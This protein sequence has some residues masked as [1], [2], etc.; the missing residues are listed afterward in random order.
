MNPID[1]SD[2][3]APPAPLGAAVAQALQSLGEG[4]RIDRRGFVRGLGL[5]GAMAGLALS[6]CAPQ[7]QP[8]GQQ[9]Q[10]VIPTPAP[11]LRAAFSHNGLKSLWNARGRDTAQFLGKLL[12]IDVI[13]YDGNLDVDKQR[14]DLEEIAEQKWDF[15]A[16]HPLAVNAYFDPVRKL[17][18]GGIPVIDMDTRLADDLEGLGVVTFLEPDNVWMGE[19]VT[20]AI[21]DAARGAAQS[22]NIEIIHT[23]GLLTHTGAQGRARGFHNVIRRTSGITVVDETPGDWDIDQAAEIWDRL[24]ERFPNV[25]AG[26]LHSDEMALAALRSIQKAGRQGQIRIGGVDGMQEA[27]AAVAAGE[28]VATVVNP[29]GRIH[30]GA[31]WV[32][33]FLATKGQLASVPKFIRMDGGIVN[34]ENAM[35]YN[36]LG[37]HLLI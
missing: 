2:Q 14:K 3:G 29:T 9:V 12:G 19:Q 33:Y 32:G 34:R 27:C 16:I 31:I 18:A 20:Q 1:Q 28:L 25:R 37:D 13:S 4:R 23:Q 8:N 24:L 7:E 6:G 17:V 10:R 21:I 15:V 26:F 11:R 22:E 30:G 35:G 5:V 36:W